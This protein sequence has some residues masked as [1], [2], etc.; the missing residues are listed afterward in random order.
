M[1][2]EWRK[3]AE[4]KGVAFDDVEPITT[5][6]SWRDLAK[7]KGFDFEID[8][9]STE[10][11][12]RK[13]RKEEAYVPAET[14]SEG[15]DFTSL[16]K[17]GIPD[18]PQTRLKIFASERGIPEEEIPNRFRLEGSDV[19]FKGDDG[20]W[21]SESPSGAGGFFKEVGAGLIS[22]AP[23]EA[24]AVGGAV[25]GIPGGP[26]GMAVGAGIGAAAGEG[27][28]KSVANILYEEPQSVQGNIEAMGNA[29]K[30]AVGGEVLGAGFGRVAGK[31]KAR[32]TVKDIDKLNKVATD[33]LD[34]LATEQGIQLTPAELTGL[35]TLITQQ[36]LLGSLPDSADVIENFLKNR[37]GDIQKSVYG[38]FNKLAAEQSPFMGYKSG[39]VGA[40]KTREKLVGHRFDETDKLYK[41]AFKENPQVSVRAINDDLD[42]ALK[43]AGGSKL[44]TIKWLQKELVKTIPDTHAMNVGKVKG[45]ESGSRKLSQL[46]GIKLSID[47]R[48]ESLMEGKLSADKAD[49]RTLEDY[50]EQILDEMGHASPRY[51]EGRE[52]F[53]ELSKP[54]G[55]LDEHLAGGFV[56]YNDDQAMTLATKLFGTR[57]SPEL[58]EESK[59][60]IGAADP[61]SWNSVVRAYMQD[62]FERTKE[63]AVD[64]TS[65][66]GGIYR[67]AMFGTE[68][69]RKLMRAA[70][71]RQQYGALEDMMT[72]LEATGRSFKGQSITIPAG[73]AAG[74]MTKDAMSTGSKVIRGGI[75]ASN[76]ISA[77]GRIKEAYEG[78]LTGKY[79]S[80]MAEIITDKNAM[81]RLRKETLKLR[82]VSPRT[83]RGSAI[84][85]TALGVMLRPEDDQ[86]EEFQ[87][88]QR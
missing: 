68:R 64:V 14:E 35:R 45:R 42:S 79:N 37:E 77:P 83:E 34:E 6:G 16:I 54:I 3:L 24:L 28:R 25:A 85:S 66:V 29:A 9:E 2:G 58:I 73:F 15:A 11:A 67:K 60:I 4:E 41:E 62:A 27:Y 63:S 87:Q 7:D 81:R 32:R 20:K 70:L 78:F 36:W 40:Q 61:Q 48:I 65:N 21:R 10:A 55:N 50:K 76:I 13:R 57:S 5:S 59:A 56:K 53:G 30:W 72:V 39:I 44:D 80:K 43:T 33:R 22:H 46:H 19:Q 49:L 86:Q 82:E 74:E 88:E 52:L 8:V 84:L 38:F 23:E 69:Q 47:A 71:D 31:I 17:A 1:A 51:T 26:V 18:D 12:R 75:E